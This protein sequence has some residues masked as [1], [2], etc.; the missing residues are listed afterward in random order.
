[1]PN[2]GLPNDDRPVWELA[3]KKPLDVHGD[4][5]EPGADGAPNALEVDGPTELPPPNI[6]DAGLLAAPKM[7]LVG[8]VWSVWPKTDADWLLVL[9]NVVGWLLFCG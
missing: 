8:A 5:E 2:E 1:M 3:F 6:E 4:G 7:V 9:P